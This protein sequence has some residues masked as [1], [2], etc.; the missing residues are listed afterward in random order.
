M[1]RFGNLPRLWTKIHS[2][3]D[4]PFVCGCSIPRRQGTWV[5]VRC[6]VTWWSHWTVC[7][8]RGRR[9]STIRCFTATCFNCR[10]SASTG[11]SAVWRR[12]SAQ[13]HCRLATIFSISGTA[14]IFCLTVLRLSTVPKIFPGM[15][16]SCPSLQSLHMLTL[17]WRFTATSSLY[18]RQ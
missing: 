15:Y 9:S 10:G 11:R 6:A 8:R 1:Y 12:N 5:P 14:P 17:I 3:P 13:H 7:W 2:E 4:K 16:G 18:W